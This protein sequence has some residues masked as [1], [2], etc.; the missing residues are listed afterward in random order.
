VPDNRLTTPECE[1]LGQGLPCAQALARGNDD[2]G[3]LRA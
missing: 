2:A 1:L 3:H